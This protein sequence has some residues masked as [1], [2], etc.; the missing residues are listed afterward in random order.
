MSIKSGIS[1]IFYPQYNHRWHVCTIDCLIVLLLALHPTVSLKDL[2][3]Y[4]VTVLIW[5][6]LIS[7]SVAGEEPVKKSRSTVWHLSH[8][9]DYPE[10]WTD[11]RKRRLGDGGPAA[12]F[13]E[14]AAQEVACSWNVTDN[15]F[16]LKMYGSF[17]LTSIT[18]QL[19][20]KM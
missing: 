19:R 8:P 7:L 12:D 5:S 2:V 18:K 1:S 11:D 15:L 17:G 6:I 20:N 14:G 3:D 16:F 9:A 10:R 13:T 4:P